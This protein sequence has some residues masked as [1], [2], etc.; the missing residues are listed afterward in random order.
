M[1]ENI[2]FDFWF[3]VVLYEGLFK[4]LLYLLSLY[5]KLYELYVELY[6]GN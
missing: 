4:V 6:W 3:E 2:Y 5:V 1:W